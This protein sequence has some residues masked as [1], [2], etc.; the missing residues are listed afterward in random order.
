MTREPLTY[1]QSLR[2]IGQRLRGINVRTVELSKRKDKYVVRLDPYPAARTVSNGK[3]AFDAA[4]QNTFSDHPG[5]TPL[6][7]TFS[8]SELRSYDD[9]ERLRRIK[10]NALPNI[11]E[12]SVTLR[13][14][15]NYLERNAAGDFSIL[16]SKAS[17]KIH[18][19]HKE[20][21][22]TA[23]NLYDLGIVM[24]R[25]RSNYAAMKLDGVSAKTGCDALACH[26][27]GAGR[28]DDKL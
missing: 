19:G 17:V 10:P 4:S 1:S 9:A 5:D 27:D 22:F 11:N 18:Y 14:L 13:V 21:F 16:W 25:R 6:F 12:L 2:V 23:H 15:G 7:F 3:I 20:Q 26:V 28:P 8:P 24:Y